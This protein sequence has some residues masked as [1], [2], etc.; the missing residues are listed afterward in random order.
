MG[1][2][3]TLKQEKREQSKQKYQSGKTSVQEGTISQRSAPEVGFMGF[4]HNVVKK[5]LSSTSE[6][7]KKRNIHIHS[8]IQSHNMQCLSL[9]WKS[10]LSV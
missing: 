6:D 5:K 7:P 9:R 1:T 8:N 4:Q 2:K 10:I 3:T